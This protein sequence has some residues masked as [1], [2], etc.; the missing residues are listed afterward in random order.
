[1]DGPASS[2]DRDFLV[3]L[4]WRI[5]DDEVAADGLE[6]NLMTGWCSGR[7]ETGLITIARRRGAA[8]AYLSL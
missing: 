7:R 6:L 5:A 1:M 3:N 2:I 8:G 4:S